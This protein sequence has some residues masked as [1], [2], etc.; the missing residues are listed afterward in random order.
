MAGLTKEW[1]S[2]RHK[3]EREGVRD[4]EDR[5]EREEEERGDS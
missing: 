5:G 1:K 2:P 3:I 4:S